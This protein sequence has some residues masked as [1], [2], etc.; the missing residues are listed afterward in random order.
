MRP[1][2]HERVALELE[3]VIRDTQTTIDQAEAHGLD[4]IMHDDYDRLLD[5]LDRSIKRQREHTLAMLKDDS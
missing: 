1:D 5:I 2:E 4:K 3:K